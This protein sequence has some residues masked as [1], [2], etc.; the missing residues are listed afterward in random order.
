M[1]R[2]LLSGKRVSEE[3]LFVVFLPC[4]PIKGSGVVH[5]VFVLVI[6]LENF[7]GEVE[8]A[9]RKGRGGESTLRT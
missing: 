9:V 1:G 2:G 3:H 4:P 5:F 8:D 6:T 7:V